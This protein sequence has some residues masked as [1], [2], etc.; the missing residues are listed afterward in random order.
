MHAVRLVFDA[1]VTA[2]VSDISAEYALPLAYQYILEKRRKL[3][4][5]KERVAHCLLYTPNKDA[6][7]R[8]IAS[9][10]VYATPYR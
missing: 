2:D 9:I 7:P 10:T 6:V 4:A 1:I 8:S 3:R 5:P